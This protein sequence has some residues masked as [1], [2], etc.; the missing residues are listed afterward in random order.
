[1]F[2]SWSGN[3]LGAWYAKWLIKKR[4]HRSAPVGKAREGDFVPKKVAVK[5]GDICN[6]NKIG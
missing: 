6:H 5:I 4:C 2:E 3:Q 1:M